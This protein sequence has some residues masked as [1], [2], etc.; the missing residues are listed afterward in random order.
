MRRSL[1]RW[2]YVPESKCLITFVCV[3]CKH[4]PFSYHG[5]TYKYF[6]WCFA[7]WRMI[8]FINQHDVVLWFLWRRPLVFSRA[9]VQPPWCKSPKLILVQVASSEWSTIEVSHF[10]TNTTLPGRVCYRTYLINNFMTKTKELSKDS[11]T[12]CTQISVKA[13]VF[14]ELWIL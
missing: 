1:K 9:S 11:G 10:N 14:A 12:K 13:L 8:Y 5:Y 2:L 3:L 4:L 6:I 7:C